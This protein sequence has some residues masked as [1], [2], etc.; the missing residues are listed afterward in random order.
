MKKRKV[1]GFEGLT[2]PELLVL[3]KR[4]KIKGITSKTRKPAMV[5][6][7]EDDKARK[8][9]KRAAKRAARDAAEE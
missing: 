2:K 5:K 7:L 1:K 9:E 8:A 4:R 6:A 3:V